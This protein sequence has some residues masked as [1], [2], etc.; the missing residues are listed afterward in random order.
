MGTSGSQFHMSEAEQTE[1]ST[2]LGS[3]WERRTEANWCC[4]IREADRQTPGGVVYLRRDSP[5]K[6]LRK[7]QPGQKNM[8]WD[9][10]FARGSLWT[11]LRVKKFQKD[12]VTG[13]P[14][15]LSDLSRGNSYTHLVNREKNPLLP[16]GGGGGREKGPVL[17][18]CEHSV[19]RRA[20]LQGKQSELYLLELSPRLSWGQGST[21]P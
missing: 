11:I 13:R 3:K 6:G 7:P 14:I 1:K 4:R 8:N 20:C 15:I 18:R 19:I 12:L 10:Q 16:L 5:A 21:Q 2:V 9:W 17:N